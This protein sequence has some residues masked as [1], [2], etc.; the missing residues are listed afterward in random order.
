MDVRTACG[1]GLAA[2][3][4]RGSSPTVKEGATSFFPAHFQ[5]AKHQSLAL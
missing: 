2:T 4:F 5:R 3:S 1:N